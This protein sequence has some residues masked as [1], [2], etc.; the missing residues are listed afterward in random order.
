MSGDNVGNAVQRAG[1][2]SQISP[3]SSILRSSIEKVRR[4]G[5]LPICLS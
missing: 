3:I 4:V 5:V 2:D 1:Q